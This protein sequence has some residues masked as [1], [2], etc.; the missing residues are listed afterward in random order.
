MPLF[1]P[2]Y[3]SHNV[4]FPLLPSPKELFGFPSQ[5]CR[6]CNIA[7]SSH[8][9]VQL[10]HPAA[11]PPAPCCCK[12]AGSPRGWL[13]IR[14][15][16]RCHIFSLWFLFLPSFTLAYSM[17]SSRKQDQVRSNNKD[18]KNFLFSLNY[19]TPTEMTVLTSKVGSV[20]QAWRSLWVTCRILSG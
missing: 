2:P 6:F 8:P 12:T 3:L 16:Y 18:S 9:N 17:F 15:A 1:P 14:L 10:L 5:D 20:R 13:S 7:V 4:L 11:S 19:L